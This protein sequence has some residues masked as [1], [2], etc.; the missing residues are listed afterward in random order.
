M[1]TPTADLDVTGAA[2][3]SNYLSVGS[4]GSGSGTTT[5]SLPDAFYVRTGGS[6]WRDFIPLLVANSTTNII[7]WGI[8]PQWYDVNNAPGNEIA[9]QFSYFAAY[10]LNANRAVIGTSFTVYS[11]ANGFG[12]NFTFTATA[13]SNGIVTAYTG[14]L[15]QGNYGTQPLTPQQDGIDAGVAR[16]LLSNPNRTLLMGGSVE[17]GFLGVS[18][19]TRVTG[20]MTINSCKPR[21][22]VT[23]N[24]YPGLKTNFIIPL[25]LRSGGL[26]ANKVYFTILMP[27]VSGNILYL[28][29]NGSATTFHSYNQQIAGG[30]SQVG[31]NSNIGFKMCDIIGA[32]AGNGYTLPVKVNIVGEFTIIRD[33]QYWT[34]TTSGS[35]FTTRFYGTLVQYGNNFMNKWDFQ[36]QAL[37]GTNSDI[38]D[39]IDSFQFQTSNTSVESDTGVSVTIEGD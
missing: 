24:V 16:R 14:F 37:T 22:A 7:G 2:N 9:K 18:G 31:S 29:P 11:A 33:T 21:I 27:M 25:A 35:T 34:G 39:R 15:S 12:S 28:K 38:Y 5:S 23:S 6:N 26:I 36:G 10:W 13:V 1:A 3:V 19:N 20:S 4:G 30:F 17:T 32:S 8:D